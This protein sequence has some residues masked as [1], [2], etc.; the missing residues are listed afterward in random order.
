MDA[1]G[2]TWLSY[3]SWPFL[4]LFVYLAEKERKREEFGGMMTYGQ[5]VGT[6]ALVGL[7]AG[8]VVAIF[9]VVYL[10]YLNPDFIDVM[11]QQRAKAMRESNNM[12]PEQINNALS[13]M[14]RFFVPLGVAGALLGSVLLSTIFALIISIF[15]KT[16]ES[17]GEIRAA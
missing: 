7:F 3:L 17:E 8:I 5:G 6:G 16:N 1:S 4:G 13:W 9:M 2:Q 12:T 14:R 15:V 11:V 10:L